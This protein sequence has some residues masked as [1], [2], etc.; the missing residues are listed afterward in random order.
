MVPGNR[1][2][3]NIKSVLFSVRDIPAEFVSF[4]EGMVWPT[5]TVLRRRY[6][7]AVLRAAAM[8]IAYS[9]IETGLTHKVV[10]DLRG[11]G[12]ARRRVR[13]WDAF[14]G[15]GLCQT[16]KG[17]KHSQTVT[18]YRATSKLLGL[19]RI[20]DLR[21]LT[22][23]NLERNTD[24]IPPTHHG[25]VVLIRGKMDW[26]TGQELPDD[27]QRK[28]MSI[29]QW[30]EAH[31]ERDPQDIRKGDP[32]AVRHGMDHVRAIED[33][34]NAINEGNLSHTWIAY[35]ESEGTGRQAAFQPNVCLRQVHSGAMFRATRLYS[36]SGVSGQGMP[37]EQRK[38]IRIDGKRTAEFDSHCH[39][40][41]LTYHMSGMEAPKGD[42]Y[43]PERVFPQYYSFRNASQKPVIRDFVKKVIKV[44]LNTESRDVAVKT[45]SNLL[46][47]SPNSR[48]LNK[49]IFS[50]EGS[51]ING[52]LDRI[53][54]VH[55]PKV[56]SKFFTEYGLELMTLDGRIMLHTLTELVAQ[57]NIPALA[58]HD[59]LL[60][61]VSDVKEA[62]AMYAE[63][64]R[65]HVGLTPE[66]RRE[67]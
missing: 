20:W 17:P 58:I 15:A 51:N 31:A 36:W 50:T 18:F 52:V 56:V 6:N 12:E 34:I 64:Y 14:T 63:T 21:L 41:R 5:L 66:L 28:P 26:L 57:Q 43:Q 46:W 29:R 25:L 37:K 65:Q 55:P 62:M 9:L 60:V 19:Q 8:H 13:I 24:T 3:R 30:I 7:V 10:A 11:S 39:A 16:C 4:F 42:S 49:T 45:I 44:C 59:S 32:Q 67:F 54:A 1:H 48:F 22:D 61:K 33:A 47:D 27:Q 23:L 2:F 40:I 35:R 38:T 53:M